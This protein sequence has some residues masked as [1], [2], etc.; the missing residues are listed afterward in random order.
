MEQNE[1]WTFPYFLIVC[2]EISRLNN[3]YCWIIVTHMKLKLLFALSSALLFSACS[4][5][6]KTEPAKTGLEFYGQ[7]TNASPAPTS[8]VE[9]PF[10]T[11]T[12]TISPKSLQG[13]TMAND[14]IV[15]K[16]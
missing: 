6:P 12:P 13:G 7:Q 8:L 9:P 3:W 10:V 4:L 2:S 14:K 5:A 11:P 16:T 15:A 1:K